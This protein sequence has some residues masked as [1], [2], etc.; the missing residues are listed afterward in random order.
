MKH[1]LEK[2]LL[3]FKELFDQ[4]IFVFNESKK[5]PITIFDHKYYIYDIVE[6]AILS[7]YQIINLQRKTKIGEIT[8]KV[9]LNNT[10]LRLMKFEYFICPKGIISNEKTKLKV[11]DYKE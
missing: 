3:E 6:S 1:N 8:Y 5:Y 2:L 10:I 7:D 11:Y 4:Q 9:Y